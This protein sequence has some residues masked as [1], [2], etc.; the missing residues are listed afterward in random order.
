MTVLLVDD[1]ISILSGLISGVNWNAL[2]VTSIRTAN[3]AAQAKEILKTERVDV[4]LCDIEMP[5][6]NGLSLLRWA[7][8]QNMDLVCVFLTSHADFLYAKE[9]IQLG[10]FDYIL[11]PARY[12]DIQATVIRALNH[13]K[14]TSVKKELEHYGIYAKN[15]P[16]SLFQDLFSDWIAGGVLPSEKLCSI[17]QQFGRDLTPDSECTTI[18]GHL[19]RWHAEPWATAEWTYGLNNI[20]ME[21]YDTSGC[22]VIPFSINHTAVGWFVYAVEKNFSKPGLPLSILNHA[23][24]AISQYF[25]CDF[26]FYVGH[27]VPLEQA[28]PQAKQLMQFKQDNVFQK[29]GVFSLEAQEAAPQADIGIDAVQMR[30]WGELLVEGNGQLLQDEILQY[31]GRLSEKGQL[32]YRFLHSFWLQF[33]Q[34]VLNTL[35]HK[36]IDAKA[37]LPILAQG[38]NA[39]SIQAIQKTVKLLAE[40]FYQPDTPQDE[41][42]VIKQIERYVEEHLDQPLS[43]SDVA[44]ALFM[45]SDYLSRLFKSERGMPLKDFI[46]TEKM[47][48]AQHLLQTTTLPVGVIAS[49]LGYENLAYFSQAYRKAMGIT[50]TNER[51]QGAS[52]K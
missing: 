22:G 47:R 26:A 3:S 9:A 45:N 23:Y 38:E 6:E 13:A 8:T 34:I 37:F 46:I 1:Q 49:K 28:S 42:K 31:V 50:P 11:Q 2:G 18:V 15:N 7:R 14:S 27:A 16:A 39:Q 10:C 5:G 21:V 32:S 48:S 12:D 52:T 51:K 41:K 30:R 24:L 33:Q 19:L 4:L 17:L 43:V 40:Q 25:P 29:S 20:I 35:W 44:S 36:G